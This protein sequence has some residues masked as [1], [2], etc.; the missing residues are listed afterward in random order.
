MPA[1]WAAVR[2]DAI[3]MAMSSASRRDSWLDEPLIQ[4]LALDVFHRD[5]GPAVWRLAA[6]VGVADVRMVQRRGGAGFLLE[7]RV[8]VGL[9][10]ISTQHL[11]RHAAIQLPIAR[12]I[13]LPHAA[14]AKQANNLERPE[15]RL[16]SQEHGSGRADCTAWRASDAVRA[17]R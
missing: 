8:A 5:V 2:A 10:D 11:E 7:P 9:Y 3:W 17:L 4:R 14:H 1:L 16:G 15:L 6:L 13:H 12:G